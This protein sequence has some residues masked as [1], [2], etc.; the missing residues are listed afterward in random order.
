MTEPNP[1]DLR[2]E[3]LDD[4]LEQKLASG[5]IP[6]LVAMLYQLTGDDRWLADPYRP[7]RAPQIDNN[8]DGGLAPEIRAQIYAAA[9]TAVRA[10]AAGQPP[11]VPAPTGDLLLRL[12]SLVAGEPVHADFEP[13]MADELGFRPH[14]PRSPHTVK[15]P[16][17]V[18][19]IGAGVSGLLAA[20]AMDLAGVEHVVFEKNDD[21]GGTW[22]E[23]HYPGCGVDTPSQ[24]YSFSF[25]PRDWSQH[26]GKRDEVEA[27]LREMAAE[28]VDRSVIRF[29]HEVTAAEWDE[30]ERLWQLRVTEPGGDSVTAVAD[31]VITA[32]GQLNR[33]KMP[34]V[35][36]AE[37][38]GGLLFHSARWPEGLDLTGRRV[39]VVG[40]GAT[41]MQIVPAIVGD[42]ESLTVYQRSPH[43]I[44]PSNDYFRT[45][46]GDI[47]WLN[48][49]LP[50]YRRWNRFRLAWTFNDRVHP[51]LHV[52]PEWDGGGRSINRTN[53]RH[54]Q[55]FTRY[56]TE[57]LDGRPDLIAKTL[58]DYPPYGKRMLLDNG[59]FAALREPHVELVTDGVAELT[60][61]GVRAGDGTERP[62]DI[63]VMATGF[64]ARRPLYPITVRGRDGRLL[65]EIWGEE[66][67]RAYL[68]VT[69]PGFP[70]LFLTY[71]PNSNIG[72]GGSFITIAECQVRY[73]A[74]LVCTMI[75]RDLATVE[76][77]QEVHDRYNR[78]L[79]EAH[80]RMIWSYG[81]MRSWYRNA[82]GRVVT[83]MPWRVADYWR[84]T[85]QVELAD[86]HTEGAVVEAR[87]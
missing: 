69:T 73:I 72:H 62:A 23:N 12:M 85:H 65:H 75:E 70:N 25:Y 87:H 20:R 63:V 28:C 37:N 26:F 46:D 43:W 24:L 9:A 45:I 83:N 86:F 66:D 48:R 50:F 5:N 19:I 27:Y 1:L 18:A 68:G 35:A 60:A 79:D 67:A 56:L 53:D 6:S 59:W 41:A 39:S 80:A 64:E 31:V 33:P 8:D 38:F 4:R 2:T 11:A 47:H 36:G 15:R 61:T 81:G 51:S 17:R 76:C 3:D 29:G 7:R 22:L 77:K 16:M 34:K 49:H 54:R 40:S 84:M 30:L 82:A 78:E 13:M 32:T 42:V 44:A 58:P 55:Y 10:W 71:G 21:V 14:A 74:D 52:D 57:Q